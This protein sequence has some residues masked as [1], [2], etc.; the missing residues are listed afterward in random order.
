MLT[1]ERI[2][3]ARQTVE[4]RCHEAGLSVISNSGGEHVDVLGGVLLTVVLYVHAT[5]VEATH[6]AMREA[7]SGEGRP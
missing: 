7:A 6:A 5:D 1:D 3:A 2:T 4:A